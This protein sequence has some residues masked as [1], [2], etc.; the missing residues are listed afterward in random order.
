MPYIAESLGDWA[1]GLVGGW[2][3]D[4]GLGRDEES[5]VRLGD[6]G[7]EFRGRR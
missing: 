1:V 4:G 3:G 7:G 6:V 5:G 2:V